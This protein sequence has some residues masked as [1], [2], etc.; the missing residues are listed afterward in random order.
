MRVCECVFVPPR[1]L[2]DVWK[3]VCYCRRLM[4]LVQKWKIWIVNWWSA[5][6]CS[7]FLI[8]VSWAQEGHLRFMHLVKLKELIR[9]LLSWPVLFL[10]CRTL[11][12]TWGEKWLNTVISCQYISCVPNRVVHL[13]YALCV[14]HRS[15]PVLSNVAH[16]CFAHTGNEHGRHSLLRF[17]NTYSLSRIWPHT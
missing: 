6:M 16:W 10:V 15:H 11:D 7:T 3:S 1:E 14:V 13:Q 5:K 8:R 12:G 2:R 9:L 4:L 17:A